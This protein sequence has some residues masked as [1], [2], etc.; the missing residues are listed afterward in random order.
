MS[1]PSESP[2]PT[3]PRL[4]RTPFVLLGL[5]TIATVAGPIAILLTL[6]GGASR[7]WP[8]DR[9]VEWWT[10]GLCTGAVAILLAASMLVGLARWRR[11]PPHASRP[12]EASPGAEG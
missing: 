12:I 7:R 5:Q 3:S 8:P 6:R 11:T 2:P 1:R 9:P 10:F 4:T